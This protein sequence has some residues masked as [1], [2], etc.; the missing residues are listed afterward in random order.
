MTKTR[1]AAV[2][3]ALA[4]SAFQSPF[5]D[6][7][8]PRKAFIRDFNGDGRADLLWQGPATGAWLMD[9]TTIA[10]ARALPLP[11]AA[12]GDVVFTGDFDGDGKTDLL[13]RGRIDDRYDIVLQ[14]GLA[15]RTTAVVSPAGAGWEAVGTGDFDGDGRTDILWKDRSGAF[16]ITYMNGTSVAQTGMILTGHPQLSVAQVADFNGDG[17]A[18]VLFTAADGSA[19][20]SLLTGYS[21]TD[22]RLVLAAGTGWWP[23][24]VGDFNGDGHADIV[25]RHPDGS[26]GVWMM[27]DP[28][29][30]RP[31]LLMAA[32]SGWGIRFVRD[33]DGD[34]RSDIVWAHADGSH[35]AWLMNGSTPKA[36]A[37]LLDGGTGWSVVAADDYDGDGKDDL[38]WRHS[39]GAYGIWLMDG[40]QAKAYRAV[41]DGGTGW[42][43]ATAYD[44]CDRTASGSFRIMGSSTVSATGSAPA[45]GT[46]SIFVQRTPGTCG[47]AYTVNF[48][49]Q[50]TLD[51]GTDSSGYAPLGSGSITF[52]DGEPGIKPV[53][54]STGILPGVYRL[55]LTTAQPGAGAQATTASGSYALT[56][57]ASSGGSTTYAIPAVNAQQFFFGTTEPGSYPALKPGETIAASFVYQQ[58]ASAASVAVAQVTNP[59][60]GGT[61]DIEI[62][63]SPIAGDFPGSNIGANTLCSQRLSYPST[64]MT[65]LYAFPAIWACNISPGQTYY[66][67]V[68][69]VSANY[70]NGTAP[71]CTNSKGC[72]L[73]IQPQSLY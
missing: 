37:Q 57:T 35:A 46:K 32:N 67:N 24:F 58:T 41:L 9:G 65:V 25:W 55:A 52:A 33:L 11:D 20:L 29:A 18:D 49:A 34:G 73:R 54:V 30:P 40:V 28:A 21:T 13:W 47:G 56:V 50:L 7:A 15:A 31:V 61:A 6:A 66:I 38:L 62:A 2:A 44:S 22:T 64:A 48:N 36:Y 53:V 4:L 12:S 42:E 69:Q 51:A 70:A 39:S 10:A 72:A 27:D 63:I 23:A 26:H 19:Y 8:S 14:D 16:R 45:S 60:Q 59:S 71:S 43:A 1:F 17:H 68:R 3:A 5:A